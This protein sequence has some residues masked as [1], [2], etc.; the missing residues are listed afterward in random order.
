M[1]TLTFVL[2]LLFLVSCGKKN[3]S[4]S[5]G[6]NYSEPFVADALITNV[7]RSLNGVMVQGNLANFAIPVINVR[8]VFESQ[9]LVG[10]IYDENGLRVRIY[11]AMGRMVYQT[12]G[13]VRN[14]LLNVGKDVASLEVLEA[15]GQSRVIAVNTSAQIIFDITADAARGDAEYGAAVVTYR[16]GSTERA[17]AMRAN[18]EILFADNR[19]YIAPRFTLDP[20]VV[21]LRD[22][23]GVIGSRQL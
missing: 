11:N 7:A 19:T 6:T 21:I 16:R 23:Q 4:G 2:C 18:G 10:V 15:N 20:Y 9:N 22:A 13:I 1:K 3:T 5:R 8:N 14:P 17:L 12:P